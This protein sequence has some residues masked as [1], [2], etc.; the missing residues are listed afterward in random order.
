MSQETLNWLD[1]FI[2]K[3]VARTAFLEM[4][5]NNPESLEVYGKFFESGAFPE[6]KE[7]WRITK[8]VHKQL[9]K[10]GL[11]YKLNSEPAN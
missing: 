7:G 10:E 6:D 8:E 9:L 11:K 3:R 4:R 5:Y 2:L 1:R